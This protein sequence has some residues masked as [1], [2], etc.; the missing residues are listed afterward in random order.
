MLLDQEKTALVVID[1]QQVLLPK[2]EEVTAA[3]LRAAVRMSQIPPQK[4][5]G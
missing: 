5:R 1:I 4:D 2:S 3:Y